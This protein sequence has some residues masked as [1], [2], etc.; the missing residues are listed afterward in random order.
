MP[1]TETVQNEIQG[2]LN[3]F[4]KPD[5]LDLVTKAMFKRN[6]NLP[7]D[8]WSL[9]NRINMVLNN[10]L[11][12]RGPKAWIKENRRPLKGGYFHILGPSSFPKKDKNGKK[13]FDENGK[14]VMLMMGFRAIKVWPVEKTTGDTEI[15]YGI[16][17]EL[18]EFFCE[19]VAE[20][21]GIKITQGFE[22]SRYYAFY[23]SKDNEIKMAT[24]SQ[25][26]FFHELAHAAEEL[27]Y[28]DQEPGQVASQEIIAEFSAVVL[29]R[30]FGLQSGT[31]NTYDYIKSYAESN[32]KDIV[33]VVAP[34]ISRID[35]IVN[36]I[37]ET[38]E[39]V[40]GM[41]VG[42]DDK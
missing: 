32:E 29:M 33:K 20:E 17:E 41:K 1:M 34:F 11:D 27:L 35:K 42:E 8:K 22:N 16:E 14:P 40:T 21:W 3:A 6:K 39:K 15:D 31:R 36:K 12:A 38:N 28:N 7:C 2:I 19:E 24:P 37:L 9:L 26:T 13:I 10:T 18:P 25:Q 4:M 5:S 30:L 23:N